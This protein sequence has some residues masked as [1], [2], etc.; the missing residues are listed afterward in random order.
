MDIVG[1]LPSSHGYRYCLTLVDRFSRWPEAISIKDIEQTTAAK[2]FLSGWIS[3]FVTPLR[4]TTDEGRQFESHMFRELNNFRG[5]EHLRTTAH[6]PASN[7]LVERMYRRLKTI[8]NCH[9]T[10]KWTE[11]LPIVL[12]GIQTAWRENHQATAAELIYGE[13][14]RL[15]GEFLAPR[16]NRD[17]GQA[18]EFI[19]DLRE[20]FHNLK[21]VPVPHH[22]EKKLLSSKIYILRK[23]FL[24]VEA[25]RQILYSLYM[26]NHFPSQNVRTRHSMSLLTTKILLCPSTD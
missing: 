7:G 5:S 20:S 3:R 24:Y 23:K 14:L 26:T 1:P 4:I 22:G 10:E 25:S 13:T 2:A 16:S 6:H 15:P 8:I 21:S 11:I 9:K 17:T 12:L 19:H 18:S